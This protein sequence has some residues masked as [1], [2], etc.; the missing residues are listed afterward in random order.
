VGR[1]KHAYN[2]FSYYGEEIGRSIERRQLDLLDVRR[3]PGSLRSGPRPT[4]FEQ[5][6]ALV[7][8]E[9]LIRDAVR[10]WMLPLAAYER[11]GKF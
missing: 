7:G 5:A 11:F 4:A 9:H 8:T 3:R 1:F 6:E 2:A 10:H